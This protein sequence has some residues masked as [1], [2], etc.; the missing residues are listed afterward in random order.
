MAKDEV[1]ISL[2]N[3][4]RDSCK[5]SPTRSFS[6]SK[7]HRTCSGLCYSNSLFTVVFRFLTA[8]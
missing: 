8:V 2:S 1:V 4:V 7:R 3:E 5:G 6:Y